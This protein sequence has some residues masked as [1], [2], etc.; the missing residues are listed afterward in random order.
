MLGADMMDVIGVQMYRRDVV[1]DF[2][3]LVDA[4]RFEVR[5]SP[6][7]YIYKFDCHL[8]SDR[9]TEGE[10]VLWGRPGTETSK[11]EFGFKGVR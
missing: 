4:L 11:T 1:F 9:Q 7:L 2:G 6:L 10:S 3:M 8:E 5:E